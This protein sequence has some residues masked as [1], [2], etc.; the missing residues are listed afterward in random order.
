MFVAA[1]PDKKK[2]HCRGLGR[3]ECVHDVGSRKRER[4]M[5]SEPW[6]MSRLGAQETE[7][8]RGAVS[9]GKMPLICL[10]GAQSCLL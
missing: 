7:V 4:G 5:H 2:C 1:Q 10:I 6:K 3:R 8:I 9:L